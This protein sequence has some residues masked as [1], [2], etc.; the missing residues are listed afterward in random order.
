[1]SITP[2]S[3]LAGN[4]S[5]WTLQKKICYDAITLEELYLLSPDNFSF[6]VTLGDNKIYYYFNG[7]WTLVTKPI[8]TSAVEVVYNNLIAKNSDK[9]YN[10]NQ[11]YGGGEY[12]T[13][14]TAYNLNYGLD[15]NIKTEYDNEMVQFSFV[16]TNGTVNFQLYSYTSGTSA[17]ISEL[18][19]FDD[20]GT[21]T[22]IYSGSV[23]DIRLVCIVTNGS[24][25]IKLYNNISQELLNNTLTFSSNLGISSIKI[26]PKA[27]GSVDNNYIKFNSVY[28]ELTG[29]EATSFF[30]GTYSGFESKR[31]VW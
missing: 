15:F 5:S 30:S 16:G 24:I 17:A 19:Y 23:T 1:M 20:V 22:S 14:S 29:P 9:Y 18:L 6:G 31:R 3:M 26:Y 21:M 8:A 4:K 27:K 28:S 12:L 2:G 11:D 7:V 10:V 13:N 25:S